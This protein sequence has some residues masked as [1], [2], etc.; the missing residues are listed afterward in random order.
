MSHTKYLFLALIFSGFLFFSSINSSYAA[1]SLV[2][3]C[4]TNTA[5]KGSQCVVTPYCPANKNLIG[6][7]C[8]ATP[9]CPSGT[10]LVSGNNNAMCKSNDSSTSSQK[11]TISSN[12]QT[13]ASTSNAK[14]S[15]P[16]TP[17]Q[18]N[19]STLKPTG[20]ITQQS[21]PSY[22]HN[23]GLGQAFTSP[24]PLGTYTQITA[25]EAASAWGKGVP[26]PITCSGSN[27][28]MVETPNSAAV[29]AYTG[30]AAGHVH[31]SSSSVAVC[32]STNDLTWH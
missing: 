7:N 32:P 15:H 12:S 18:K 5:L 13:P 3:S 16:S 31:L 17:F 1:G 2:P 4:P 6:S 8:V 28:I 9:T 25:Q 30:T 14:P 20:T 24:Y 21:S 19:D 26:S 27:A 29:W 23:N 10:T 22:T 11:N